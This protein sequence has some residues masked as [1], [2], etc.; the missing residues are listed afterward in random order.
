L[1]VPVITVSLKRNKKREKQRER[2]REREREEGDTVCA[3]V[4][5]T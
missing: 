5:V 1:T 2:E 4:E 3:Y